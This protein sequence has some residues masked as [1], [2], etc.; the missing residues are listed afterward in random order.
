M[1]REELRSAYDKMV[2]SEEFRQSAKEK[3]RAAAKERQER[4]SA[5]EEHYAD[6]TAAGADMTIRFT[7]ED[8]K[9]RRN[10]FAVLGVSA[11][12]IAVLVVSAVLINNMKVPVTPPDSE[13]ENNSG[14][15]SEP[16]TETVIETV[17]DGDV[18]EEADTPDY[19]NTT[20][21]S[22]P[23]IGELRAKSGATLYEIS[24]PPVKTE[25]FSNAVFSKAS[26]EALPEGFTVNEEVSGVY[27]DYGC[28]T[29]ILACEGRGGRFTVGMCEGMEPMFPFV[30]G[31]IVSPEGLMYG[32][33]GCSLLSSS[34]Y[35]GGNY[36]NAEP[37]EICLNYIEQN[38][39]VYY[40]GRWSDGGRIYK[41]QTENLNF[42]EDLQ[43]IFAYIFYGK[44][45]MPERFGD[46][47]ERKFRMCTVNSDKGYVSFNGIA[48]YSDEERQHET[49]MK[50]SE[51][52]ADDF[53]TNNIAGFSLPS[54]MKYDGA[55]YAADNYAPFES[56][57]LSFA[58]NN[59]A[60]M[61]YTEA[62]GV[63]SMRDKRYG[64]STYMIKANEGI[65][66]DSVPNAFGGAR[67]TL[68]LAANYDNSVLYAEWKTGDRCCYLTCENMDLNDFVRIVSDL[69]VPKDGDIYYDESSW[70]GEIHFQTVT[71]AKHT[72]TDDGERHKTFESSED[73]YSKATGYTGI[74][75]YTLSN[76]NSGDCLPGY[77]F[78]LEKSYYIPD[79][80]DEEKAERVVFNFTS[81]SGEF[82]VNFFM[83]DKPHDN[84][85][86]VTD[87]NGNAYVPKD[88]AAECGIFSEGDRLAN[89]F[90]D[91]KT[92]P[93]RIGGC[94]TNN[95]SYYYAEGEMSGDG[96]YAAVS[97]KG[98]DTDEFVRLVKFLYGLT[99]NEEMTGVVDTV[100]TEQGTL[101]INSG[102]Y[103]GTG[104]GYVGH[105][106]S[107]WDYEGSEELYTL[108]DALAFTGNKAFVDPPLPFEPVKPDISYIANYIE[109][110]DGYNIQLFHEGKPLEG[111][112]EDEKFL[113]AK[114]Y[115]A[116]GIYV[117][118]K[119]EYFADKTPSMRQ[120]NLT[121][122][123]TE[124]W[125]DGSVRLRV[126]EGNYGERYHGEGF[127]S[128][129]PEPSTEL[130]E[131]YMSEHQREVESG[132][133]TPIYVSAMPDL[134]NGGSYPTFDETASYFA[135]FKKGGLYYTISADGVSPEDF[136]KIV[137]AVY[138]G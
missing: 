108:D 8:K 34:D 93:M 71:P 89:N 23:G 62:K 110:T 105:V 9:P 138:E 39:V 70:Y 24:E 66:I 46:D 137:K 82:Y 52:E 83:P 74:I 125:R 33:N 133:L 96:L 102:T 123:E 60:A 101:V 47:Y 29:T 94:H 85:E 31:K 92:V 53:L 109:F 36:L 51:E 21:F 26:I 30:D 95:V 88:D 2:L 35:Y 112:T 135:G 117:C 45:K 64:M 106:N 3:L 76:L 100:D 5:R 90:M 99:T 130:C 129:T 65:N 38:G 22:Y 103:L 57:T 27:D 11:A 77:Q 50:Y 49:M 120:F 15:V 56:C 104:A 67:N 114:K 41:L 107:D 44:K 127:A 118:D 116:G 43:D 14:I 55:C 58:G 18:T 131:R 17:I 78:D 80:S 113:E 40:G 75:H 7:D 124:D 25:N 32:G 126:L 97:A 42:G 69:N 87:G 54:G 122:N 84:I 4:G 1:S 59:N 12:A 68:W 119:A 134:M 111:E 13:N 136:A 86:L 28:S 16:V 81:E 73:A 115:Y 20:Y 19:S 10:I 121:F 37:I 48:E 91:P 132:E 79:E 98:C 61:T 72:G 128:L 63:T 6:G